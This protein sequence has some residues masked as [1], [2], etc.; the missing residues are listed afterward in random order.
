MLLLESSGL[1]ARNSS[2]IRFE[3]SLQPR[4]PRNPG[5]W[6]QGHPAESRGC[7]DSQAIDSQ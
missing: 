2:R 6:H 4:A 7:G 5:T 1:K 3:D